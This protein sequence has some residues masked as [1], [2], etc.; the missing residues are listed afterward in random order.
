MN[1]KTIRDIMKSVVET[2]APDDT[3]D[4]A[5]DVMALDRIRHMPVVDEY[6]AVVG[7]LSERDLFPRAFGAAL[8]YGEVTHR[9]LLH[10]LRVRDVMTTPAVTASLGTTIGEA[11]RLMLERKIGC[12]PVV[13]GGHLVGIVTQTDL[14]EE[15]L[16]AAMN[17]GDA[18]LRR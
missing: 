5:E 11:G 16:G 7:V 13:Y 8:G 2:L 1:E 4:V 10:S 12:L 17:R 14:L 6:G 15:L 9:K 18:L 3:L